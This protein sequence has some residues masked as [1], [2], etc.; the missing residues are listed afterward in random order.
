MTEAVTE[1]IVKPA[2][3]LLPYVDAVLYHASKTPNKPAIGLERSVLTY[4]QLASAIFSVTSRCEKAALYPGA[5][6]GLFIGDPVWHICLIA[7]LHRLGVVSVSVGEDVAVFSHGEVAAVLHDGTPPNA[8]KGNAIL[9]EAS[10]F[11]EPLPTLPGGESVFGRHDLCRIALTSGTTGK[12]KP[13]ALSPEIISRRLVDYSFRGRFAESER[14]YCGPNFR[15]NFGFATVFSALAYGK[16]V[17]FSNNAMTAA[18][19]MSYFKVDLAVLSVFQL[20]G[21]A[22]VLSKYKIGPTEL[23]QIHTAGAP[24]SDVLRKRAREN[25]SSEIVSIYASTEAG[26]VA[27]A[28]IERLGNEWSKGSVGFVVPW[29]SV[30][31]YDNDNKPVPPGYDGNICINTPALAPAFAPEMRKVTAP[32]SFFPGDFGRLVNN[33]L[34]IVSGRSSELINIGGNK[35]SPDRIE[36]ALMACEGVKDAAVFAVDN[37]YA[38]PQ[39]CAAIVAESTIDVT[40]VITRFFATSLIGPPVVK[41]VPFIPRDRLGKILRH[42]LRS[43]F[44]NDF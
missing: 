22:E 13:I 36:S 43:D 7:A 1:I 40:D 27:M 37:N 38:L 21:F 39:I 16:M 3:K 2:E 30:K 23:R 14:L 32:E 29:A 34:L 44:K 6:V 26:T 42:Q 18:Q 11:T 8:F 35:I 20:N 9:V 12:A 5:I 19:V 15:S 33:D 24:V 10:W 41:R 4:G 25:I 28:P 17:C 31:I